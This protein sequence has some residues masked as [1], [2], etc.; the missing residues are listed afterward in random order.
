MNVTLITLRR[1]ALVPGLAALLAVAACS[2]PAP[3]T[4]NAPNVPTA[5]GTTAQAEKAHE[6]LLAGAFQ[7]A[8][9]STAQSTKLQELETKLVT[10]G[11]P[12]RVAQ[13]ELAELF[14]VGL[15]KGALDETAANAKIEQIGTL[16]VAEKDASADTLNALHALLTPAQRASALELTKAAWKG[17]GEKGEKSENGEKGEK[18]EKGFKHDGKGGGFGMH[19]KQLAEELQLTDAQKDAFKAEMESMPHPDKKEWGGMKE[20]MKAIGEAF[21]SDTFDAK[22]LGV[23]DGAVK[24]AQKMGPRME[25]MIVAS[26]K[27]L[28]PDQR[29]KLA[30]KIREHVAKM[31]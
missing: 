24:M 3:G 28:T 17:K 14:A 4:A 12:R 15:E 9:L 30:A 8:D 31:D 22:A 7:L 29:T 27:I 20:K 26:I 2:A 1:I 10:A 11:A 25:K 18:G 21:V 16:A 6:P 13:R 19:L 5:G 23:G